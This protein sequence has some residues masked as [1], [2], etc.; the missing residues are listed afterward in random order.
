MIFTGRGKFEESRL[1]ELIGHS[2]LQVIV[3]G[4]LG[5][6]ISRNFL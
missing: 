3:G 1:I 6:F 4:F 5:I 2:P